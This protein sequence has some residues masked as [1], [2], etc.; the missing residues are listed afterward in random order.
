M[1]SRKLSRK[2]LKFDNDIGEQFILRVVYELHVHAKIYTRRERREL[3]KNLTTRYQ[4][5]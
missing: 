4:S 2:Y 1:E 5:P 3:W